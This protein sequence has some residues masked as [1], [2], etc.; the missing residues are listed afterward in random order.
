MT[1]PN[2]PIAVEHLDQV[3]DPEMRA[4]IGDPVPITFAATVVYLPL[5]VAGLLTSILWTKTLTT[6]PWSARGIVVDIVAGAVTALVL[7]L[8]T[9]LLARTMKPFEVLEREFRTI[10]GHLSHGQII[11]IAVLSGAAEELLFR[12]TL[13]PWLTGLWG[14][15][16]ALVVTSLVFGLLH[17]VP[18]R[19]FLPWTVFATVVGFICGGLF[20]VFGSVIPPAVTHMLL[21]AI[22][23]E[24]IVNGGKGRS[25][26]A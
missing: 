1:H 8:V 23:L 25:A 19:V 17:F 26:P 12:G 10:L 16:A 15:S 6:E 18:D 13:Q 7:V 4:E 9:Y 11:W 20:D 14:P 5:L 3:I 21:N 2:T 22:N 24:L